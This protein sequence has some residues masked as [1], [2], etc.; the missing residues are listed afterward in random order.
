MKTWKRMLAA[1]MC[2]CVVGAAAGVPAMAS[3]KGD[4]F[5]L[6]NRALEYMIRIF[7]YEDQCLESD[8]KTGTVAE[9]ADTLE[10]TD[11]VTLQ[12]EGEER[13]LEDLCENLQYYWDK[14]QDYMLRGTINHTYPLEDYEL[15]V[16]ISDT[17]LEEDFCKVEMYAKRDFRYPHTEYESGAGDQCYVIFVRI[18]GTWY[19]AEAWIEGYEVYNWNTPEYRKELRDR[20]EYMK[21]HFD[22]LCRE[23]ELERAESGAQRFHD[24]I[25]P[26]LVV[27]AVQTVK[28]T[29]YRALGI[30]LQQKYK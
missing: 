23:A 9:Y 17:T 14:A 4:E 10:S 8:L 28:R 26:P 7:R 13:T 16:E 15:Q 29:A 27:K 1:L 11:G 22:E 30:E 20:V 19:L 24:V 2:L 5:R 21:A 3:E 12:M 6:T 18:E 25:M